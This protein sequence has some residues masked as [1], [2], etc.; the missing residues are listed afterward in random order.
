MQS[1]NT[2]ATSTLSARST[3]DRTTSTHYL[4]RE[5]GAWLEGALRAAERVET[6]SGV[7]F[8]LKLARASWAQRGWKDA[9]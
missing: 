6:P 9:A 2:T 1:E 5:L 8:A 3:T 7:L 4:D